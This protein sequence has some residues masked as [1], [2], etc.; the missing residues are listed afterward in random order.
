MPS[1]PSMRTMAA[2]WPGFSWSR[3]VKALL[4]ILRTNLIKPQCGEGESESQEP[5]PQ[6]LPRCLAR[7]RIFWAGCSGESLRSL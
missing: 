2:R 1:I 5:G 3:V 4:S 7:F 6:N